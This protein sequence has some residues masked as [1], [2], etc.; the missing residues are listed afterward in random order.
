L[1]QARDIYVSPNGSWSGDGSISK[2]YSLGDVLSGTAKG[3]DTV[4]LRGGTYKETNICWSG[5]TPSQPLIL[6]QYPGE[7]AIVDGGSTNSP[8][9]ELRCGN[10]W[11]WGFEIYFSDPVRVT[12]E[13]GSFPLLIK[14]AQ[15]AASAQLDGGPVNLKFI[16]MIIHDTWG[17]V[18]A[19]Q[20]AANAEVYGSI[21]YYDG[22]D[23][24]DR[25][26]G[27]GI[28]A[29]NDGRGTT[30]IED[31]ILFSAFSHGLHLYSTGTLT[32]NFVIEGNIAIDNGALSPGGYATNMR[33]GGSGP[34]D[35]ISFR[36]NYTYY[37]PS[38]SGGDNVIGSSKGCANVV[39]SGNYFVSEKGTA[40]DTPSGCTGLSMTGNKMIGKLRN[41]AAS[42]YPSNTYL[43]TAP[44]S[45]VEVFV[46]PNRYEAGRA[47]IVV[48]NWARNG[49]VSVDVSNVLTNGDS[50]EVRDAQNF[51]GSPIL[52]GKYYGGSITIP[53]DSIAV[54]RAVGN[55]PIPARHTSS[56]FG[57]FVV[58]RV[59]AGGNQT[60]VVNAGPD[61]SA[62][63][64]TSAV[65]NG[66]VKDDG[67]PSSTVNVSWTKV[68]GP[69]TVTF[70]APTNATTNATVSV[71]GTYVLRLTGSD[72][73]LSASDDVVVNLQPAVSTQ[74]QAPKVSSG[75]AIAVT[76]PSTASLAG[77][78]SDDGLP[79]P[80]T[81]AWSKVSGPGTVTFGTPSRVTTSAAFSTAGTYVLRLTGSDSALSSS[82]DVTVTVLAPSAGGGGSNVYLLQAESAALTYP[83]AAVGSN[84]ISISTQSANAGQARFTVT[85]PAAGNYVIWGR[86]LAPSSDADSFFVSVNGGPADVYDTAEG[87]W[88]NTWQWT[89]VNGRGTSGPNTIPQRVFAL[90]S[91][92]N[93][94][95]FSG[96]EP[97]SILDAIVVTSNLSYVPQ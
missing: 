6:R 56:Q 86:V 70:S 7:R 72:G 30:R 41:F 97:G 52:T 67:L 71:A 16:N 50:F 34:I 81:V 29:Q 89:R 65:L 53:M 19:W 88:S 26:H 93:T 9:L 59:P 77:S 42:T 2:P 46:R 63:G 85:V 78:V 91:G 44:T 68:S 83:M 73:V 40:L 13:T 51:V 94:I 14:R 1:V 10:L 36:N 79:A 75:S 82:A 33:V 95:V 62:V 90:N 48:Y 35:H 69:G 74:N 39:V 27:H 58:L 45:G 17:S 80:V 12:S 24:P 22:W 57:A 4:W 64:V 66:S 55:V 31:N 92:Q 18:V 37:S 60:P 84:P 23:A 96:R 43:A 11:L 3:G 32:R 25:G 21:I 47:N 20:E 54:Q 8:A 5:G 28:Y 38:Q 15:G 61:I 87:I 76:L 49:S